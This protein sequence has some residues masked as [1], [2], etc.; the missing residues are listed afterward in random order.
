VAR[1][2][3]PLV[4]A[5]E[6]AELMEAP[7]SKVSR[8]KREGRMPP[9]VV[10]LRATPVWRRARIEAWLANTDDGAR[11][12][13]LDLVGTAEAADELGL[14]SRSQIGRWLRA[15]V[16]PEPCYRLR[17]TPVW[18]RSDVVAFGRDR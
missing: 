5:S 2:V 14:R 10:E 4:G 1:E 13:A 9:T 16:F 18:W 11:E 7:G 15:G 8:L 6:V 3:P 12:R 17:A